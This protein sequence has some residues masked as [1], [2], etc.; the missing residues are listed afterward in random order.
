MRKLFGFSF[1]LVLCAFVVA[2]AMAQ[3][4]T[5]WYSNGN[6][7]FFFNVN[8]PPK[9][10]DRAIRCFP[11]VA[12]FG[13][14]NGPAHEPAHGPGLDQRRFRI[15]RAQA[16]TVKPNTAPI[17]ASLIEFR[18]QATCAPIG[19]GTAGLIGQTSWAGSLPCA[20]PWVWT[21]TFTWTSPF[22][23]PTVASGP[24]RLVYSDSGELNQTI[25]NQNYFS[26]SGNE[27]N[28]SPG[29]YS[30]FQDG[31]ATN[32]GVP[33]NFQLVAA[34]EWAHTTAYVDNIL[35]LGRDPSGAAGFPLD[36]GTGGK[37]IRSAGSPYG[38]GDN[39]SWYIQD[40]AST[41]TNNVLGAVLISG[42]ALFGLGPYVGPNTF[43][44]PQ[45]R[46]GDL[47]PDPLTGILLGAPGIVWQTNYPHGTS[48]TTF[49]VPAGASAGPGILIP[50]TNQA[51][52]LD[53]TTG[54][55]EALTN[56][57]VFVAGDAPTTD[58]D[59]DGNEDI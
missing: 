18:Q 51:V 27:R 57:D 2:P 23:I 20:V 14:S 22:G 26:G 37:T 16:G 8:T 7:Y 45:G 10:G 13:D 17:G 5:L 42:S 36:Y 30:F 35:T 3:D 34:Q 33:V 11:S 15:S 40:G 59:G 9:N 58:V 43:P 49:P 53:F 6:E 19:A 1:A 41:G 31:T 32:N 47:V 12:L 44:L 24:N 39:T 48:G 4:S 56:T 46:T 38:A 52:N 54:L 21:I 28:L 50:I 25:A 29:G 55:L